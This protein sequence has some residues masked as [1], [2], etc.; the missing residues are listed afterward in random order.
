MLNQEKFEQRVHADNLDQTLKSDRA[1]SV[2]YHA[3]L[4]LGCQHIEGIAFETGRGPAW[5]YFQT[6][7]NAYPELML[8]RASLT[9]V[10]VCI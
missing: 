7:L 10:Q 3:V 6:A 8:L 5:K 4:S 9:A 1:F 2:L